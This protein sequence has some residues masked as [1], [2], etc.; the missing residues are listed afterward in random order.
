MTKKMGVHL[1][2]GP[3]L[4]PPRCDLSTKRRLLPLSHATI[5]LPRS[6]VPRINTITQTLVLYTRTICLMF[7]LQ[8]VRVLFI[9][10]IPTA[11]ALYALDGKIN[12]MKTK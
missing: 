3:M 2:W 7:E 11:V 9:L 12:I 5:L 10:T 4:V 8:Y 1:V 6:F